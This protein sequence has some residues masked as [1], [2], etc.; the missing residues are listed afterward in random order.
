MDSA[1]LSAIW[2]LL[3]CVQLLEEKMKGEE[4]EERHKKTE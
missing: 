4:E 3:E 2:H 1:C